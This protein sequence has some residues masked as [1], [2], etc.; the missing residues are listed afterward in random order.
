MIVL[1]NGTVTNGITNRAE[2]EAHQ[3][4]PGINIKA[5]ESA[6]CTDFAAKQ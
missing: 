6:I 3:A 1:R 5:K 4:F 2:T